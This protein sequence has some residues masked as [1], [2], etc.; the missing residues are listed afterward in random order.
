MDVFCYFSGA[1]I[2]L[3]EQFY[4]SSLA[5]CSPVS[6]STMHRRQIIASPP[7]L[8]AGK[9]KP[10][11]LLYHAQGHRAG[12]WQKQQRAAGL[13]IQSGFLPFNSLCF[14]LI[15]ASCPVRLSTL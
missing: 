9:P 13:V 12:E 3:L 15:K 7:P 10:Q 1:V 11:M 5:L 6:P 4:C 2:R 8:K 14:F